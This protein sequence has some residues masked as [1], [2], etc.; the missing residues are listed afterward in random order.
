[1]AAA[2]LILALVAFAATTVSSRTGAAAGD[3]T[4][5]PALDSEEQ[6]FLVLIN[7]HRAAN[8]LGPLGASYLL[9]KASQWKSND[10]GVNAYFAHD[11]LSRT[12]VQRI[13][14][15][16]YNYNAWLGENIAGGTNTA[17]DAFNIW[18][19]SPGHN[20]N[21]LNSN[22][23][24]VGIGRAFVPGSPFGWYWTTDF[25][26]VLDAWPGTTPT[27]TPTRTNTPTR[28]PTPTNTATSTPSHTPTRTNTPAPTHTPPRRARRRPTL[29]L[30]RW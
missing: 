1:M 27:H 16:G 11:D 17:Q 2:P 13:R 21:M 8:G 28:T 5:D 7:N 25:G 26:S 14:D 4:T 10:L 12:W 15:C 24:A 23:T 18:K 29:P 30:P 20:A 3:C 6:A 22:Y 19:N 9:S